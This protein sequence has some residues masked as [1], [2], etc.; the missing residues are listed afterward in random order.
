MHTLVTLLGDPKIQSDGSYVETTYQFE[1]GNKSSLTS[2][3]SFA[4]KE[5]FK[6]DKMVVLGTT[7]SAW[8]LLI[9]Y[10]L[11]KNQ[12]PNN[13]E[14]IHS[15]LSRLKADYDKDAVR[16]SD[17]NEAAKLLSSIDKDHCCYELR[18]IPYGRNKNEQ[19]ETLQIMM[20]CFADNK[21]SQEATLDV[22]NGLRHLPMLMQQSALLLQSLRG[23][24]IN[25][26]FYGAFHIAKD[27]VTPIMALDGMLEIDRWTKALHR[28]E[29][30]GDYTAFNEPLKHENIPEP[31]LKSLEEAAYYE[32][33]FNL[34]EAGNH[35]DIVKKYLPDS[36]DG[37]GGFF[38]ARFNEHITWSN[39]ESLQ[40]RQ[41]KLAYF[42]LKKGDFV[43]A[44][45]FAVESF[46]T[47][48][49]TSSEL[50]EQHDYYIRS[51]AE[52]DFRKK[53]RQRINLIEDYEYLKAIR[54]CLAHGT[55]ADEDS[56]PNK[57]KKQ[58]AKKTR[59]MMHSSENLEEHLSDL[60]N[61][62]GINP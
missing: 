44:S 6:P 47:S 28:Y 50:A 57:D 62:L 24:K 53:R 19:T 30:D 60:F 23:V 54:N 55:A 25:N 59:E 61:K 20:D 38:T 34:T 21:Q 14:P 46:I 8:H 45:I 33:T 13:Q 31:A 26:I 15:L 42:Y 9:K 12:M 4:I 2:Y 52:R 11:L 18:L 41:G 40:Q 1:N 29:Q 35:L 51:D 43:R 10:C 32:R 7:K 5:Q 37:I 39:D 58:I 16:Q 48:L 22:S 49:L 36:F 27:N 17:L 3:T 56:E